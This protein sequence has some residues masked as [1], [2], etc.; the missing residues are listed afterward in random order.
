MTQA[1]MDSSVVNGEGPRASYTGYEGMPPSD[2][3]SSSSWG[4]KLTV[5]NISSP[6]SSGQRL[7]LAII[8]LILWVIV[9]IIVGLGASSISPDN[10][11]S[12]FLYPFLITALLIFSLLVLII[13][14]LFHS[15]H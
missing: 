12:R 5:D 4:Q 9:F 8:S 7:T 11:S 13:N 6:I 2:S 14:A 3:Y 15:L 1:Q 10:P